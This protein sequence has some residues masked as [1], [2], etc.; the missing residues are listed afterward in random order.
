[1]KFY[2][3][4]AKGI[5]PYKAG[6]QPRDKKYIKLN[7]N[8][9]AYPPSPGI[10]DALNNYNFEDLRLYPDPTTKKLKEVLAKNK[11]LN[12]ENIFIGNGSDEVLSMSFA[13]FFDSGDEIAFADITYSFY[14]VYASYYKLKKKIIPL[15][16]Y[17]IIPEL[18]YNLHSKGII[19]ANPN[20][21]TGIAL[22]LENIEKII[23]KNQ[24]K[25]VIIDQA[26]IAFCNESIVELTKKYEN[27]LVIETMSK[28]FALAGIRCGYAFGNENL[29]KALETIKNSINNYTINSLSMEVAIK[30][31]Q[32]EAYYADITKKIIDT[33]KKVENELIK[34]GADFIPSNSNFIFIKNEKAKDIYLKLKE[35]GILVRFFDKKGIDNFL[36]VTIGK[37]NEMDEFLKTY[38]DIID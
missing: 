10:K 32:D 5:I 3:N 26:Y 15:K 23:K 16:E 35:R 36:R 13:A 9:N 19:I 37:E 1:M 21:P 28:S 11:N 31:I 12:E 33:R 29:I 22:S 17:Q 2:S 14:D 8:E 27:I 25:I 20:A 30:A 4:L 24:D 34:M 38:K 18:Y 7:T 6:E